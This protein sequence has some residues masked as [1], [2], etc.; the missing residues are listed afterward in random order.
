MGIAVSR[1]I[2]A[3]ALSSVASFAVSLAVAQLCLSRIPRTAEFYPSE[4]PEFPE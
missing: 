4:L 1:Q 3:V 2:D